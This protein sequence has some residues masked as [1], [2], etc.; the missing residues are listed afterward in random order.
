MSDDI[1]NYYSMMGAIEEG[2]I[3]SIYKG[4][5][6][7]HFDDLQDVLKSMKKC[8]TGYEDKHS[9]PDVY[10]RAL[11]FYIALISGRENEHIQNRIV[12]NQIEIVQWR[13]VLSM[14]ALKDTLGLPLKI[15]H[16][17][18]C[19]DTNAFDKAIQYPPTISVCPSFKWN[20]KNFSIIT[21]EEETKVSVTDIA[22]FSPASLIYPV[23]DLEKKMPD[24]KAIRWFDYKSK[25]FIDPVKVFTLE[26]AVMVSFWLDKNIKDLENLKNKNLKINEDIYQTVHCHLSSFLSDLE[27]IHGT[28][29]KNKNSLKMEK[30]EGMKD[31][32]NSNP[33]MESL[34]NTV[35]QQVNIG[36]QAFYCNELF[37]ERLYQIKGEKIVKGCCNN[38]KYK[39]GN[40]YTFLPFSKKLLGLDGKEIIKLSEVIFM[41]EVDKAI[42]VKF[43]L[44]KYKSNYIDYTKIYHSDEIIKSDSDDYDIAIWPDKGDSIWKKRYLFVHSLNLKLN[45]KVISSKNS[46]AY[47][48]NEN[49]GILSFQYKEKKKEEYYD[50]GILISDDIAP[51]NDKKASVDATV[52]IDFGTSSTVVFVS[53]DQTNEIDEINILM[54]HSRPLLEGNST[55]IKFRKNYFVLNKDDRMSQDENI[56]NSDNKIMTIYRR[57]SDELCTN[58]NPILDG[59]IYPAYELENF[60]N[61]KTI[62]YFMTDI[63]W[64]NPNN[65][66]YYAA[67]IKELCLH[68]IAILL[69]K[70][71]TKITWKYSFPGSIKES[72]RNVY[73]EKWIEVI[74]YLNS[75]TNITNNQYSDYYLESQASSLYFVTQE[76]GK[77]NSN[78]G[79]IVVDIGGGSTDI[80]VWKKEN[81][82]SMIAQTSV[83]IAGHKL[84]TDWMILSL[85][86]IKNEFPKDSDNYKVL[87]ELQKLSSNPT[88]YKSLAER[89]INKLQ[90]EIR[91]I[92]TKDSDWKIRLNTQITFG[93]ALLFYALGNEIGY[94]VE[95]KILN[96]NQSCQGNFTIALGGNGSKILDWIDVDDKKSKLIEMFKI[97]LNSR[98]NI[99]E[100]L[101]LM[102]MQ[103]KR[104]KKEVAIG[105]L[106]KNVIENMDGRTLLE[107]KLTEKQFIKCNKDFIENFN[108]I[109]KHNFECDNTTLANI[110][111]VLDK[112]NKSDICN[113]FM[114]DLFD[115]YYSNILKKGEDNE[116]S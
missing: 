65:G 43:E 28:E 38:N 20:G 85:D 79:Y 110:Y 45:N 87:D 40:G 64:E 66:A 54:D 1:K 46:Y 95:K 70:N 26:E 12:D 32:P 88:L 71:I 104:P 44:S 53:I 89:L 108:K 105:L 106:Q 102:I 35:K 51:N 55:D 75:F 111:S 22:L 6:W 57:M 91:T 96:I 94:L 114:D 116:N 93:I 62:N 36:N 21:L 15:E 50:L 25:N 103:S 8:E 19:K 97:G 90:A 76:F 58:V 13:G 115:K 2:K 7:A 39:I 18:Y 69:D 4:E 49:T 42:V 73:K 47:L 77:I 41:S 82:L 3:K 99:N 48:L 33:M 9:I 78:K 37:S 100:S 17:E 60:V 56:S 5:E 30:L 101:N 11:Q 67:F 80:A 63:K 24:I 52:A 109:F 34:F 113:Y 31:N 74:D 16:V 107:E 83:P 81:K 10:G 84:F 112:E 23:A 29:W 68:V 92:Y 72:I 61:N 27:K 59:I 86:D 98:C 14:L